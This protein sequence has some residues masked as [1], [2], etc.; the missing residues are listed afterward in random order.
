VVDTAF[1][2]GNFVPRLSIQ[3]CCDPDES[4]LAPYESI[5]GTCASEAQMDAAGKIGSDKWQ[6]LVSMKPLQAGYEDSRYTYFAVDSE[7]RF[8]HLRINMFPDGGIARLRVH[9]EVVLLPDGARMQSPRLDLAAVENGGKILAFSD[10]HYGHPKNLINPG[11]SFNMARCAFSDRCF[12]LEDAIG[13]NTCSLEANM[14]VT[15]CIPLG[16][17]LLLPLSP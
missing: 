15:N 16:S 13:S 3:A 2:S 10:T 7:E 1:F 12:A 4:V 6:H 14:R 9:G 8:T 17:P 11:Q 5:V